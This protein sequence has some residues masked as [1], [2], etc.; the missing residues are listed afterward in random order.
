MTIR[1]SP[2]AVAFILYTLALL[3]GAFGIIYA[4]W[5]VRL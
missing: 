1:I 2:R 5:P 3:G 4:V